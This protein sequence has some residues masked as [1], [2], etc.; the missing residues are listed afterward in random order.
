M[1][2]KFVL[3]ERPSESLFRLGEIYLTAAAGAALWMQDVNRALERHAS[4]DWGDIT[5]EDAEAN[6]LALQWGHRL[7]WASTGRLLSAYQ[8]RYGVKFWI[9]TDADRSATTVLLPDDY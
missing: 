6:G 1:D 2:D 9:I 5:E 3:S 7:Y 4:G 8:D